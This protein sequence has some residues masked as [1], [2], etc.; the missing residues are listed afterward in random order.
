MTPDLVVQ[1]V[2][3]ITVFGLIASIAGGFFG[4][5]IG[6]NNAFG[7]TGVMILLAFGITFATGSTMGFDYLAFGPLFGPHVAFAG[8]AAASAYAA[9]KKF[10]TADTG[11]GRDVNQPL[12]GLGHPDVLLVGALFGVGGYLLQKAITFIPWF[13]THTDSV[14]LTVMTSGIVARLLFSKQPV[15]HW[16]SKLDDKKCWLG[17]QE[18][19]SQ[20][21]TLG[22]FSGLMA[23][24]AALALTHYAYQAVPGE[25]ADHVMANAQA[26]PFAIS[27]LCIFF[28]PL[29]SKFP[30]THHMTI[31]A[32]LAAVKFLPVVGNNVWAALV[33]GV[34][35][36]MLAAFLGEVAQRLVYA[37]G[38]T[39][40]DP[41]ASAIWP[42]NT[43]I[44][45]GVLA[46]S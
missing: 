19:P 32:A 42:M 6:G 36:G 25:A 23:A 24:G 31:T 38:D 21:L 15:F 43:L 35:A 4:A 46:L 44:C 33:I 41:P 2:Q 10:L 17:W 18:K 45:L 13:G 11:L 28:L 9:K 5:A 20:Y 8:G 7:F 22:A 1:F 30:V 34:V 16:V 26:L 37:N 40:I 12:A 14:A 29:G 3:N 27:A 39:H